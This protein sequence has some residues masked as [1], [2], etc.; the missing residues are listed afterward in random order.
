MDKDIRWEQRFLNFKKALGQLK[1]AIDLNEERSLTDL[2]QQ[3]LIQRFE[4]TYELAWNTLKDYIEYQ[5]ET[6][7]KGSRDAFRLAFQRGIITKG[8]KWID[9]IGSR[10]DSVHTYDEAMSKNVVK[11]VVDEYFP[12]FKQLETKLEEEMK[13]E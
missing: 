12:I 10:R 6:D 3:G 2:E 8:Q 7:I 1:Q 9:M 4:F 13:G 11:Q 5:G